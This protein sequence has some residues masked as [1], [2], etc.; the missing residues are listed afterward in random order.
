MALPLALDHLVIAAR[1]LA[2]GV[3]WCDASLGLR[4]GTGGRHAFMGTH[5]RVF[6]MG[7]PVFPQAYAEIIAIDPD[8]APPT[9]HARWFD[10]DD[11]A[12]QRT[13]A[14]DGPQLVHWVARCD[15]MVATLATLRAAGIDSGEPQAA[16]RMTP[17]GLLRWEIGVRAD[18]RR[19][20]DGAAPALIT[21]GDVHPTDSMPASGVTLRA[22]RLAGWPTPLAGLLPPSIRPIPSAPGESP[23]T[24][25]LMTPRG[26]VTLSAPRSKA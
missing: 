5:N 11:R 8:V 22:M 14:M 15:D 23:L 26:A 18:G 24:V 1:T 25:Q 2:E 3:D 10:L 4:P 6:G 7:S 9:G 17:Q 16:E 13:L 19:P 21:W 20:L 12:L